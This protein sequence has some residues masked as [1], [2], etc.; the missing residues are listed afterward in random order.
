M[1]FF[2]FFLIKHQSSMVLLFSFLKFMTRISNVPELLFKSVV[3]W[4]MFIDKKINN[5]KCKGL[6]SSDLLWFAQIEL[7]DFFFKLNKN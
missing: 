2:V 3:M 5:Q 7:A 6:K 4:T 1:L